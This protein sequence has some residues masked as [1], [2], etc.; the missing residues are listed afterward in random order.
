LTGARVGT[1]QI[2]TYLPSRVG[3]RAVTAA[4]IAL[5]IRSP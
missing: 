1:A 5:P 3:L 2:G 4:I